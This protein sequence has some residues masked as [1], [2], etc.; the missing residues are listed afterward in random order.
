M[1]LAGVEGARALVA[2]TL[3]LIDDLTPQQ[4]ALDSAAHGWRVQDVIAHQAFFFQFIA[5]PDIVLPDNPGGTSEGLNDAGVRERADWSPAEVIEYYRVQSAAGLATLEAL[6]GEELRDNPIAVAELGTYRLAQL[7]D[8][9]SFDHLVHLSSDL[10]AP[11]GPLPDR[12]LAYEKALD[13]A[14]DWMIAGLPKMNG[15]TL[16]PVLERPVGLRLTGL[17]ER[18]FVLSR[19]DTGDDVVV[20]ETDDLPADT[21]ESTAVDFLRWATT[22]TAWRSH[23]TTTGDRG[24]VAA[25]LDAIDI[26]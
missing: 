5:D 12:P 3:A 10:L 8:A 18:S 11:F 17:T 9:V 25:V 4:W 6:Q 2:D 19:G 21:A 13:P 7:S 16:L 15:T 20:V 1:S 24:L 14:L 22:R 26:I 23:V